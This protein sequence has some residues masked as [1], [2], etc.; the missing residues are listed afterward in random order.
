MD[1]RNSAS[2]THGALT[3]AQQTTLVAL[4]EI[5]EQTL[6][7]LTRLTLPEIRQIRQ[8]IADVLPVGNLPALILSG[9]TQ[10][11]GRK[12]QI[13]RA[14][15]DVNALLRGADLLPKGLF[16]LFIAGPATVL[17]AYQKILQL[18]GKDI[19]SAFPQGMWQFYLEFGLREDAARHAN[20]A[21]GFQRLFPQRDDPINEATAWLCAG[22]DLVYHYSDL[23]TIDW[24]ERVMLRL[25]LDEVA[26]A[27]VAAPLLK[28]LVRD[29]NRARP[30]RCP[31]RRMDYLRWRLE[32]FELFLQERRVRLP[33]EG[34]ARVQERY[35]ARQQEELG[36][37]LNQMTILAALSPQPH[38]EYKTPISLWRAYLGFIWQGATY[39]FPVC[40]RN[41]E[42]SP[43]CYLPDA[44]QAAK[45]TPRLPLYAHDA[46]LCDAQG[47]VLEVDGGG[48]VWYRE[49]KRP[50]GNLRP[51]E[52]EVVRAWVKGVFAAAERAAGAPVSDLDLRLVRCPRAVQTQV[53][54]AL[55]EN[56]QA[57]LQRLRRAPILINWDAA[58]SRQPLA[59]IRRGRRGVGD[60]A[61]T[62]FRTENS[63]VFD[64]SHI[65]FDGM[66]GVAV[67]EIVTNNAGQWYRRLRERATTLPLANLPVPLQLQ[68]S[69]RA[70]S[71]LRKHVRLTEVSAEHTGLHLDRL[72]RL[73]RRLRERGA[74]LTVND[75]L[76]LYRIFH[77]AQYTLS[78]RA[79]Q[80]LAAL[81]Q[82]VRP[83]AYRAL[84]NLITQTLKR[85]R[86][87]N[88]SLLV[89]M[90][91][92]NVAPRERLYPTTLRNPLPD[93][94]PAYR[95]TRDAYR[96]YMQA[97]AGPEWA[98]FDQQRRRLLAH[99]KVFGEFQ[100][101]V[102]AVTMRGES[103]NTATL[104]LLAH[105]PPAMQHLL[106]QIPQHIGVLNEVIKGNEVFSNVGR[107]S[108]GSSLRRF[109]SAKDDGETKE[110]VWG[111]LTDG[112]GTVHII[113]RD[114][115]PFVP[116]LLEMGEG[117]LANLLAQDYVEGYTQ[118]LNRFV[119]DLHNFFV[120][121]APE[122]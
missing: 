99:L 111:V 64:Q 84:H 67:A 106:D 91:A 23:L 110:L 48:R 75:V 112:A 41:A 9:L 3:H 74:R 85:F 122:I 86:E 116:K 88:P 107:V 17:Y 100:D 2:P 96:G 43:W 7:A 81:Q 63:M 28:T 68:S 15:Q 31:V 98:T 72:N 95:D 60:H 117:E 58:D 6:R 77:A 109:L 46:G 89:P 119:M 33:S 27:N 14:R 78:P 101:T 40:D 102:K 97:Q 118:G 108:M 42:G 21:V 44:D 13:D 8:E 69:P 59:Y 52:P 73:R 103:F 5:D 79:E 37:Y 38:Q 90:D 30:Y 93:L 24:R 113:L 115:R 39:L 10:M 56:T 114:F 34:Q 71:L 32:T 55:P 22:I 53:R 92:S 45:G 94:L 121:N 80:A 20:E 19:Q 104:R 83:G 36:A 105:L 51:P 70:D 57:A 54:Q 25:V 50:L 76:L 120:A 61:L 49:S 35:A 47:N 16:G 11:K 65:F 82:R 12:V 26:H 1:T 29:W 87:T 66:W 4:A 18:A 62:I